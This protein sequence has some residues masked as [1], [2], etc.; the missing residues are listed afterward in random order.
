MGYVPSSLGRADNPIWDTTPAPALP[1]WDLGQP[2]RVPCRESHC[3]TP[4]SQLRIQDRQAEFVKIRIEAVRTAATSMAEKQKAPETPHPFGG[5]PEPH[6]GQQP[7]I[8]LS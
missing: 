4:R 3:H 6:D 5:S 1:Q 2:S 8:A 7:L